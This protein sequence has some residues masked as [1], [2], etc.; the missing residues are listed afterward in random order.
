MEARCTQMYSSTL[1]LWIR[2]WIYFCDICV[3]EIKVKSHGN[4]EKLWGTSVSSA[5]WIVNLERSENDSDRVERMNGQQVKQGSQLWW[6][7]LGIL[8][9]SGCCSVRGKGTNIYY[10]LLCARHSAVLFIYAIKPYKSLMR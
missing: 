2:I 10:L 8:R 5:S 3:G 7:T 6:F 4:T 1:W 9:F